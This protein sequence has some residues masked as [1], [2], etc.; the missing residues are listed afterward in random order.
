MGDPEIILDENDIK[1]ILLRMTHNILEEHKGAGNLTLIGI[2]TRGVFLSRRIRKNIHRR[3]RGERR[4]K[5][6]RK[7]HPKTS[8]FWVL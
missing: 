7:A 5:L 3:K 6:I 1:R 2:Q 4:V 8:S